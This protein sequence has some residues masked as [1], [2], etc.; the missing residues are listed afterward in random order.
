[1]NIRDVYGAVWWEELW[2]DK[3]KR[4]DTAGPLLVEDVC[5]AFG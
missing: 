1:M 3:E 2:T 4:I 5:G